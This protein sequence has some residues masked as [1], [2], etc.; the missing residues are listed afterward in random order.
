MTDT[1]E[2][3][4]SG[5][6]SLFAQGLII[7]FLL[8]LLVLFLRTAFLMSTLFWVPVARLFGRGRDVAPEGGPPTAD[9]SVGAPTSDE[10]QLRPER[11]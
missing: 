11:D 2:P 1:F 10:T 6:G 5:V 9:H 8:L 4:G 7:L 3:G